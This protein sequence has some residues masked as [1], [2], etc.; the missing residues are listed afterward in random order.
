MTTNSFSEHQ[1]IIVGVDGSESSVAALRW[2]VRQARLTGGIV[3][4]VTAWQIPAA[5]VGYGLAPLSADTLGYLEGNAKQVLAEAISK[6]T[7]AQDIHRVHSVVTQ[8]VPGPALTE[9]SGDADLLVVG[10]RGLGEVS[11]TLHGSVSQYCL[12][13]AHCPVVVIRSTAAHTVAA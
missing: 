5:V 11:G 8:A 13:H 9:A 1:R 10:S 12:H 4:A 7:S 6:A 3:D 2:A